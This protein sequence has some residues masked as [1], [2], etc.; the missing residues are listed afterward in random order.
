MHILRVAGIHYDD[1]VAHDAVSKIPFVGIGHVAAFPPLDGRL[2]TKE[3]S[4]Y[5][6]NAKNCVSDVAF[7]V[8]IRIGMTVFQSN[9][10][11]ES[12]DFPDGSLGVNVLILNLSSRILP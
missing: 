4:F 6:I 11:V 3:G 1:G 8:F 10:A 9:V 12:P 7:H 5:R 2:S